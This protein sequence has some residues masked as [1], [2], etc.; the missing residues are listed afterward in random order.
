[1]GR[2][3]WITAVVVFVIKFIRPIGGG[4]GLDWVN[5]LLSLLGAILCGIVAEAMSSLCTLIHSG[6]FR[7]KHVLVM[8]TVTIIAV[9]IGLLYNRVPRPV[10]V[11][12]FTHF[13]V[14]AHC[15]RLGVMITARR[16]SKGEG[17]QNN[18]S[19]V[20]VAIAPKPS[21]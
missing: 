14:G 8:A 16:L 19:E 15:F 4:H 13:I 7:L 3:F 5:P 12:L 6:Q 20:F 21:M 9:G 17:S 10:R 1:V 2:A 11:A 18:T